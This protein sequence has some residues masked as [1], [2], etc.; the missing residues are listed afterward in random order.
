MSSNLPTSLVVEDYLELSAFENE[1]LQFHHRLHE[2]DLFTDEALAEL[3]GSHPYEFVNVSRPLDVATEYNWSEGEWHGVDPADL[4]D[5]VRRGHLWINVRHLADH[6]PVYRELLE[7]MYAELE[8]KCPGLATFDRYAGLL[9]SSPTAKVPYHLD[10]PPV[11]LWHVR[12]SKR[13]WI[14][15]QDEPNLLDYEGMEACV[16][17]RGTEDLAYAE[18]FDEYAT[19]VDLHPGMVVAWPQNGP[20]RVENLDGLN[21]SITGEHYTRNARRRLRAFRANRFLRT[22]LGLPCRSLETESLGYLAKQAVYGAARG[23]DKLFGRPDPGHVQHRKNFHV[24]PT[25][26]NGIREEG[27]AVENAAEVDRELAAV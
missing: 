25:A 5:L 13:I 21:V 27:E 6:Q 2:T 23:F 3:V 17:G 11:V 15:P 10:V 20:H 9:I 1:I 26:P 7:T 8:A 12:G 22:K 4:V 14:Y 16:A 24:D 18:S 19:V